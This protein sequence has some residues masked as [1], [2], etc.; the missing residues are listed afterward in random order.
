MLGGQNLIL[1]PLPG[2]VGIAHLMPYNGSGS[3]STE[4]R[5]GVC[6]K[7]QYVKKD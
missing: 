7:Q 3:S 5:P 2:A 1:S 4:T 6:V